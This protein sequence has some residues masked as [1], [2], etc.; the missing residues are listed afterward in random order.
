MRSNYSPRLACS[1]SALGIIA[2]LALT[3]VAVAS[4]ETPGDVADTVSP[5]QV[6]NDHGSCDKPSASQT[7]PCAAA[8][9]GPDRQCVVVDT[10]PPTAICEVVT[11]P[12]GCHSDGWATCVAQPQPR[13][14]RC[15]TNHDCEPSQQCSTARGECLGCGAPAGVACLPVCYGVCESIPNGV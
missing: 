5:V 15:V 3:T 10:Q 8:F 12:A 4:C 6:S 1:P 11:Q 13:P 9:C 7:S 2:V 14:A